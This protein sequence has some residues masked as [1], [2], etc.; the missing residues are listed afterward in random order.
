M[1]HYLDFAATSAIRPPAVAASMARFLAECGAT[2]GRGG[3]DRALE[4]GRLAFRCRRAVQ[5]L[6]GLPG[7][8]GRVTFF[9]NATAAL[10]TA[11]WGT[12][13]PG[14]VLVVTAF[15]HNAV[16][17]PAAYLG[18][19]RGVDVRTLPGTPDGGIDLAQAE[20]LLAGARM[21][22]VNAASNVLG[23]RLPV[24]ELAVRARAAGALVLLDTAQAA[25]H[26]PMQCADDGVDL[27]AFTGHKGMLGPQGTGGLWVREGV[28][29]TPLLRGGTGGDSRR[30]DMPR[31]MPDRLEA[32]SLHSPGLAGLEAG[33]E[34][35]LARG[36]DAIHRHESDLKRRLWSGLASVPGVNVLSPSAPDG[37]GIVTLVVPGVDPGALARRLEQEWGVQGR[38]GLHCA[39]ECHR[40]LGSLESGALRLSVGWATTE[41]DVNRALEGLEALAASSGHGR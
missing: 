7:D 12:L 38:A 20:R 21:L 32:G 29:V 37:V 15:D 23:H 35:V 5:Q 41:E 30:R 27:V 8:P 16:L 13:E 31:S 34:F 9:A 33:I 14:D 17:R 39:P 6:L 40:V 10:N 26:V 4:A 24:R 19:S 3:H 2:P 36:V 25:G 1:S 11:L 28:D 22:S 18:E